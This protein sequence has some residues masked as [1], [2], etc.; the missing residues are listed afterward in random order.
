MDPFRFSVSHSS[1]VLIILV[2]L[3][4]EIEG[5]K[6]KTEKGLS[7]DSPASAKRDSRAVESWYVLCRRVSSRCLSLSLSREISHEL[8][9]R[10]STELSANPLAFLPLKSVSKGLP[11]TLEGALTVC[12]DQGKRCLP[13]F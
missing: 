3:C 13:V 12:P 5:G 4:H 9:R 7:H 10:T 1:S 8:S 6:Y 11:S 2:L